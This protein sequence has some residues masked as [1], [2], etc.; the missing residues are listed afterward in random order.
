[1]AAGETVEFW[2]DVEGS[3]E[4]FQGLCGRSSAVALSSKGELDFKHPEAVLVH[5]GDV[6]DRGTG[7]IRITSALVSLKRRYPKR[8][9]LLLGN[10]DANKLRFMSEL[11]RGETGATVD[12]YW[13]KRHQPF[14][15]YCAQHMLDPSDSITIL[16][17]MLA[18]TMGC[19][20]TFETRRR[21]LAILRS[22][23]REQ[24]SDS[25]VFDSFRGS[26]DPEG[27]DH[28]M[29]DYIEEG[30][31]AYLH[32][33]MLFIHGGVPAEQPGVLPGRP[34]E[35]LPVERWVEAINA[36]A[37][38]EVA[39]FKAQ[40]RWLGPPGML[41]RAR[42]GNA[43]MDYVV[44]G[45][46]GGATVVTTS[47]LPGG[48]C[49]AVPELLQLWF[50]EAGV[51]RVLCGH[52]PHGQC[53][54]VIRHLSNLTIFCCDTSYSQL[55]AD[56][57]TN[58]S[59]TRGCAVTVVTAGRESTTISGIL[60]DGSEHRCELPVDLGARSAWMPDMLVGCPLDNGWWVKAAPSA[61][62]DT[63]VVAKGNAQTVEMEVR[64]V[65]AAVEQLPASF[66]AVIKGCHRLTRGHPQAEAP[67]ARS[68]EVEFREDGKTICLDP[69]RGCTVC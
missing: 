40:P 48:A 9:I 1:M 21:E 57:S 64:A 55:Q 13:D 58:P 5:G 29:L 32:G 31:I 47:F 53:P 67:V 39:N 38:E 30:Q 46:A 68:N 66:R 19:P 61:A 52:K 34:G 8:V 62:P 54:S 37:R 6:V 16:K 27:D 11:E 51:L 45:G 15:D 59:N 18:C 25:E 3:W 44:P 60:S 41:G 22:K 24:V 20:N 69:Q 43:L 26:V 49:E 65:D 35:G 2:T 33:D 10:R 63:V 4:Y 42:G 28:W 56:K 17:W 36:W 23:G 12:V 50:R 14:S 7:D